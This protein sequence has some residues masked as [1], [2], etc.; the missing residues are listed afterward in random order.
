VSSREVTNSPA[1]RE[2]FDAKLARLREYLD[3][4]GRGAVALTDQAS[5]SWLTAGLTNPIDRS[6]PGSLLWLVVSQDAVAAITTAVEGPRLDAEAA[7]GELGI[8][9]AEVPWYEPDAFVRAAEDTAGLPW[10]ELAPDEDEL[11]ALRLRLLA[12]EQQRLGALGVDSAQALEEAVAEWVPG[13]RDVDV[14]AR[15][16]ERL[17]RVGAI[18]VCLIVGGD[19]RVERFRHPLACGERVDRLVMAVVVAMRDGLHA[20]VTRF[21]SAGP[22]SEAVRVA[23]DASFGVEAAMLD[24][25]R[26]DAATYGD[27]LAT[28]DAAYTAVGHAGAW[29]EHYQGG[30]VGYRQRGVELAPTQHDSRWYAQSIEVGHAVAWNPS[31]AGGGKVE[32]TFLVE[33]DGLR[34]L[35]DTGTWPATET[36]GGRSRCGVLDIA[37]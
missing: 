1:R 8:G 25:H 29:Q 31:V 10:S 34:R 32:D 15:V 22:V 16:A 37:R 7:L 11:T 19:E 26:S 20:A 18:P 30:P 14:Q 6:D 28:C 12:S 9:L 23:F 21:A 13:E 5:V 4:S 35:T 17:E 2:E 3:V 33:V 36:W 24:A 27:V